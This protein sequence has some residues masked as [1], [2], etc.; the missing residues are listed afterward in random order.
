MRDLVHCKMA[1]LPRGN[2]VSLST[3]LKW[4][5]HTSFSNEII[6]TEGGK[7]L[8]T[9]AS[10]NSC[11][12]Y[13]QKIKND[14]RVKGQALKD[15]V[16]LSSSWDNYKSTATE[17]GGSSSSWS[18]TEWTCSR[19]VRLLHSTFQIPVEVSCNYVT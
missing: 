13:I 12:K 4:D 3:F 7:T 16:K 9:H 14:G 11:S 15:I 1:A 5:I 18:T 2:Q 10:F 17:F 8:V 6:T 19:A